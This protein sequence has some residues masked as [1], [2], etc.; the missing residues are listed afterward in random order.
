MTVISS[1]VFAMIDTRKIT[2]ISQSFDIRIEATPIGIN[3]TKVIGILTTE[4]ERLFPGG[5]L[6]TV[7]KNPAKSKQL[8]QS[9]L[10]LAERPEP[11]VPIQDLFEFKSE[12]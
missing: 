12:E 2:D 5:F 3:T 8:Y 1:L 10:D 11:A 4:V 6:A 7:F 9:C